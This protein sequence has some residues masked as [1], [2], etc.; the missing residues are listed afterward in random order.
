MQVGQKISA[1]LVWTLD[2]TKN[3]AGSFDFGRHHANDTCTV[4]LASGFINQ[5]AALILQFIAF[6]ATSREF[7]GSF[8]LVL[9]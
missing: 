4:S 5:Y 2:L 6:A 8:R 1:F 7:G 9:L 3:N